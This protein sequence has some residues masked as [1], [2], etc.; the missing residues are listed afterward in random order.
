MDIL[1]ESKTNEESKKN[2]VDILKD[3]LGN[4]IIKYV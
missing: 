3:L 2:D 4:D 1:K